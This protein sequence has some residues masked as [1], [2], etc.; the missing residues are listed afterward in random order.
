MSER[1]S[2]HSKTPQWTSQVVLV[3]KHLLANARDTRDAG[4]STASNQVSSMPGGGHG[5][6]LQFSYLENPMER[7]AWQA[8]VRGVTK[9]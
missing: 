9:R 4:S 8:K 2:L 3:V 1:L 6:P 5:N 7:G